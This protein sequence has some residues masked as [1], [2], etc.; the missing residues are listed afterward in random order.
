MI[1]SYIHYFMHWN[2][3]PKTG[4]DSQQDFITDTEMPGLAHYLGYIYMHWE[5]GSMFSKDSTPA[6]T[7]ICEH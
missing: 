1:H 5:T 2:V 7:D 3:S 6:S 4:F